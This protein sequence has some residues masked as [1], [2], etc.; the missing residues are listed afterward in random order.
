MLQIVFGGLMGVS[1]LYGLMQGKG[2][3]VAAAMLAAAGDAVE[4]ALTLSGSFA[5]FCGFME[6]GRQAGAVDA[7]ARALAPLLLRLFGP[8]LPEDALGDVTLN[9][10]GNLLG[11]GNAATPAGL[12][13]ARRMGGGE[14]AGNALCLFLVLNASAAQLLP[15]TVLSLRAAAGSAA[16]GAVIGPGLIASGIAA[17][18]GVISCKLW[19]KRP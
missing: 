9:L 15:T 3:Q 7:L 10:A 17:A 19:E 16:P 11:L 6:I 14:R 13:A 4:T 2:D 5:L 1:V 12:R 18:V 8:G